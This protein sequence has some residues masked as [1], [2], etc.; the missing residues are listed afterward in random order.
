[1][2]NAIVTCNQT[3]NTPLN[4]DTCCQ[5]FDV[6]TLNKTCLQCITTIPLVSLFVSIFVQ[7]F[8]T[9]TILVNFS[10]HPSASKSKIEHN[11]FKTCRNHTQNLTTHINLCISNLLPMQPYKCVISSA[12]R[13]LQEIFSNQ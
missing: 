3:S 12:T 1:M 5:Y 11:R 4:C 13:F 10:V 2:R 6:E 8:A 9:C 7:N